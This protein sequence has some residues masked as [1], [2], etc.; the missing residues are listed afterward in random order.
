MTQ[1]PS[2]ATISEPKFNGISFPM[3]DLASS[4]VRLRLRIEF[5]KTIAAMMPIK[6]MHAKAS[7]K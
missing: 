1:S 7:P 3:R 6:P 4:P 5:A 2:A